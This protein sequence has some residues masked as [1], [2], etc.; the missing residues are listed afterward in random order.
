MSAR[1]IARSW[2]ARSDGVNDAADH[3]IINILLLFVDDWL[4]RPYHRAAL[5]NSVA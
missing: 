3:E 1:Q 5:I 4:R 2:H